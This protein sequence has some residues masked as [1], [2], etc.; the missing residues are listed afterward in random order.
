[1]ELTFHRVDTQAAP[2][3]TDVIPRLASETW[4]VP[5]SPLN[6]ADVKI[7]WRICS[8]G[9]HVVIPLHTHTTSADPVDALG[10]VFQLG[11]ATVSQLQGR[12][13]KRLHLALGVPMEQV[14][15]AGRRAWEFRFGV[16]VL[17]E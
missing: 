7:E 5:Y 15:H 3:V 13:I 10:Y 8:R 4:Y 2:E 1:M 16:G 6:L 14:I 11:V 12:V 9:E 17:F